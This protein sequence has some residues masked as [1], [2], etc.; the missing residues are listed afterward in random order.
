MKKFSLVLM[1]GFAFTLTNAQ[2]VSFRSNREKQSE[3]SQLFI[4]ESARTAVRKNFVN[5]VMSYRLHQTVTV[6]ISPKTSFKGK[7]TAITNDAPGLE[8]IIM[9]STETPGL[10]LSLSKLNIKGE[11]TVYRGVMMSK[12]ASDMLM[13]EKDPATG[14]Y[15][16]NKKQVSHMIPD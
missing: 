5:D 9:Q 10:V 13:L 2:E 1:L 15:N 16:W 8:T 7:V 14:E 3:K 12:H 11:G 4:K 6:Q